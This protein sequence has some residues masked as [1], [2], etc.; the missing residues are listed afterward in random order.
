MK[1]SE[2]L[3]LNGLNSKHDMKDVVKR[4][5]A[6]MAASE[7]R[8]EKVLVTPAIAKRWLEQNT[9]SNRNISNTTVESYA[10]EMTAGRWSLTHQ[11]IA[12]NVVGELVDGQHRL[13]AVVLSGVS[14]V[15]LV[16]TGLRVEYNSPIDVGYNRS[17]SHLTGHSSRWVSVVRGLCVLEQ[18][19]PGKTFKFTVGQFEEV[20]RNH[21]LALDEVMPNA[22]TRS[23]PTGAVAALCY[24][25]P[26]APEKI[27]RLAKEID[28]GELLTKGDPA[29]SLRRW[30]QTG[31]HTTRETILACCGAIHAYLMGKTLTKITAGISRDTRTSGDRDGYS[32]YEWL[33][34]KRRGQRIFIGT[35]S[36]E[37]VSRESRMIRGEVEEAL[38]EEG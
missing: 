32:H 14:V 33:V 21:K 1:E 34:S 5:P 10:R 30:V 37:M 36:V 9:D 11:G 6:S 16:T 27:I 26:V 19:L 13:N 23:S 8:T 24:A 31:R 7:T 25:Y 35:P 29:L 22:K 38:A 18:G 20:A 3:K 4:V 2:Q 12:F 17:L 15:M 28:T